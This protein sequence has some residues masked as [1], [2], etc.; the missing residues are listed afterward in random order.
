MVLI[1][2]IIAA[3]GQRAPVHRGDRVSSGSN[4]HCAGRSKPP[5]TLLTAAVAVVML[6]GAENA[7]ASV[8]AEIGIPRNVGI[9]AP[10]RLGQ[11][12]LCRK[13][14]RPLADHL[15]AIALARERSPVEHGGVR[16]SVGVHPPRHSGHRQLQADTPSVAEASYGIHGSALNSIQ[17]D[18]RSS[19]D[20]GPTRSRKGS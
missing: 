19:R 5:H 13:I 7:Q 18:Q 16:C 20:A 10:I 9:P 15:P 17:S 12:S 8:A 6:T 4:A 2:L 1:S 14:P 3:S 11:L